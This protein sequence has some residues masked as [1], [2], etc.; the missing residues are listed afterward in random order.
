MGWS[1]GEFEGRDI[2]YGVPAY[3]D[4]RSCNAEID[5][6]LAY[7]CGSEPYGGIYGCG[8]FFCSTHLHHR[9]RRGEW[10]QLCQRCAKGRNAFSPKPEH[11]DWMRHKL[12]DSSWRAW[13]AENPAIVKLYKEALK[14]AS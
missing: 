12:R 5:R 7:V 13:R 1:L 3:C 8:L 6:G 10:V 4:A 2:G 14:H 11:P 9:K